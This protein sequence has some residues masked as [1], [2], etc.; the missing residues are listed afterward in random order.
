[1]TL[2]ILLGILFILMAVCND[3]LRAGVGG[4]KLAARQSGLP[5]LKY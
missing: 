4:G 2:Q 5:A 3:G 1:V